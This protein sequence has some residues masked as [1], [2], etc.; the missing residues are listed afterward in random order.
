MPRRAALLCIRGAIYRRVRSSH[1]GSRQAGR[2]PTY[3]LAALLSSSRL[4]GE[5][6]E[7]Y[8]QKA[9]RLNVP[10]YSV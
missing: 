10:F 2:R 3:R 7:S 5:R 4:K 9:A 8:T 1:A 6:G